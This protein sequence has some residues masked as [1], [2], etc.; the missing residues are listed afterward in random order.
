MTQVTAIFHVDLK[1]MHRGV[2]IYNKILGYVWNQIALIR[3]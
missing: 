2:S 1:H 3:L